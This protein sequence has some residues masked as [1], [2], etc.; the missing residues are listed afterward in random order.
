[1]RR[2][3][4]SQRSSISE[5]PILSI[6]T[7]VRNYAKVITGC[8]ESALAQQIESQGLINWSRTSEPN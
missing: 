5:Y 4:H 2:A 6:I 1:M 7:V 8:I 3:S